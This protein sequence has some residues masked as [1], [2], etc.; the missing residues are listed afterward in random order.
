MPWTGKKEKTPAVVRRTTRRLPDPSVNQSAPSDP[1]VMPVGRLLAANMGNSVKAPAVVMRPML[2]PFN[3]VNQ[4]APSGP[5]DDARRLAVGRGN[6]ELGE[7]ACR[8]NP[9]DLVAGRFG[10]PEG[11]V[12]AGGDARRLAVGRGNGELGEDARRSDAAD[13][14]SGALS[15]PEAPS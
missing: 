1:V 13:L 6:G 4:R 2:L 12:R 15:E 3:S 7:D 5:G 11:A 8:G 14:V 10:E 9:P